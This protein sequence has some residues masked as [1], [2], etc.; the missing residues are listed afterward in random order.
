MEDARR[1][2][3][4]GTPMRALLRNG[5]RNDLHKARGAPRAKA[6]VRSCSS[7]IAASRNHVPDNAANGPFGT[8]GKR[9]IAVKLVEPKCG[10]DLGDKKG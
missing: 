9:V 10:S 3:Y 6:A 5:G 2:K 1:A 4:L 8:V 7:S